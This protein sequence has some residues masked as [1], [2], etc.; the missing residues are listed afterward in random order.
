MTNDVTFSLSQLV[1]LCGRIMGIVAFLTWAMKPIKTLD[2][3]EKRIEVLERSAQEQKKTDR[4]ITSALNA[5]VNHMIDG[6]STD[7]LKRVRDEFQ[8]RIINQ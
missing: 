7:E 2:N 3:H 4:Y 8:D 1:W 5:M 6:N